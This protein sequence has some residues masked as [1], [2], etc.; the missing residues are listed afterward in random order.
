MTLSNFQQQTEPSLNHQLAGFLMTS[1]ML[2]WK[3]YWNSLGSLTSN[4]LCIVNVAT[5][6]WNQTSSFKSSIMEVVTR[7]QSIQLV[8]NILRCLCMRSSQKWM[9][10]QTAAIVKIL[11]LLLLQHCATGHHLHRY[12]F[13]RA[14]CA[15]IS[16]R[17]LLYNQCSRKATQQKGYSQGST[18]HSSTLYLSHAKHRWHWHDRVYCM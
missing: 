13:M 10:S 4:W 15:I 12:V 9:C 16:W 7:W 3:L 5:S 2:L 17:R 11:E 18:V 1:L 8:Q 6:T 14:R